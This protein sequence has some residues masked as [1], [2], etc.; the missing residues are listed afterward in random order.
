MSLGFPPQIFHHSCNYTLHTSTSGVPYMQYLYGTP[1]KRTLSTLWRECKI[2][3]APKL[4]AVLDRSLCLSHP[5][6][7]PLQQKALPEA[8]PLYQGV[9]RHLKF[10]IAPIVPWNLSRFLRNTSTSP[11]K[12]SNMH[13]CLSISPAYDRPVEHLP[14]TCSQCSFKWTVLCH[15]HVPALILNC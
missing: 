9:S 12:A 13:E 8:V 11:W 2:W 14:S 5:T 10:P 15:T 6:W 4:T 1:N 7:P 3:C